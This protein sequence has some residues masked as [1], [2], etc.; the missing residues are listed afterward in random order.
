VLAIGYLTSLLYDPVAAR[1]GAAPR[2]FAQLRP[3]QMLIALVGL[4]LL[5]VAS[6]PG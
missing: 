4:A 2:Y 3:P 5:F 6:A 1:S